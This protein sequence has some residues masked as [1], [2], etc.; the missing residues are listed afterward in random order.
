MKTLK[1][2]SPY[3]RMPDGIQSSCNEFVFSNNQSLPAARDMDD[4]IDAEGAVKRHDKLA[5]IELRNVVVSP[6]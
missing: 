6:K 4:D 2:N 5:Q 1:T 3:L